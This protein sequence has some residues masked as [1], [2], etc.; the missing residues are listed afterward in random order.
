MSPWCAA[1]WAD[2]GSLGFDVGYA[3]DPRYK[4]LLPPP[5]DR[6]PDFPVVVFDPT[7]RPLLVGASSNTVVQVVPSPRNQYVRLH[8]TGGY[9]N[10]T[11]PGN[12]ALMVWGWIAAGLSMEVH[13]RQADARVIGV[14]RGLARFVC[15]GGVAVFVTQEFGKLPDGEEV[16][17]VSVGGMVVTVG[18]DLR[19]PAESLSGL[20]IFPPEYLVD[21]HH[22][23]LPA[24]L[25]RLEEREW[26]APPPFF[27]HGEAVEGDPGHYFARI[28]HEVSERECR[29]G[30]G[31]RGEYTFRGPSYA[32]LHGAL[33]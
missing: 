27:Y 7:D 17:G 5:Y 4:K 32:T 26:L 24:G 2:G 21:P 13:E 25:S 28:H 20:H 22:P 10:W 19:E 33:I 30:G 23:G 11:S 18:V 8:G 31:K 9:R 29:E 12:V 15:G 1:A 16:R 3:S 14:S 6:N